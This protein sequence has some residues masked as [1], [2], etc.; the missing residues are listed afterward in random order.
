ME[1]F[2]ELESTSKIKQSELDRYIHESSKVHLQTRYIS[3]WAV[4]CMAL[5]IKPCTQLPKQDPA[6]KEGP[7]K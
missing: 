3:V 1:Y 2:V 5:Q 6:N 4:E 7:H